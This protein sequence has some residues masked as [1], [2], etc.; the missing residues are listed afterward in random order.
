MRTLA[1][2]LLLMGTAAVLACAVPLTVLYTNDLH[3]RVDRLDGLSSAI[4]GVRMSGEAVLWLDAGDGWHDY[5]RPVAA[6]WGSD[7][8][9][10]WMNEAGLSA[11]V[12]GNH[13]TY[14]GPQR[15]SDRLSEAEFPVLAA[16]WRSND[17]RI[18]VQPSATVTVGDVQVLVI[19][20][21][22][23]DLFPAF[24]YPM[25]MCIDPAIAVQ[26]ELEEHAGTYDLVFVLAHMPTAQARV[27][28]RGIPEIDLFLTGHSH[29]RTDEPIVEGNALIVQAGAFGQ[30][31]GQLR[32]EVD[33][34]RLRVVSNDLDAIETAPADLRAGASKW[35]SV[36][37][38][39]LLAA[40]V[41]WT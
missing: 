22:T 28:A 40:A 10:A 35:L 19:G 5:R 11:M 38:A 6:V 20:L 25:M 9:V 41:W 31:L 27:L 32:L 21:M 39:I 7:V 16:N 23:P 18:E 30:A 14:L 13:E 26:E 12:L 1:M 29:E 8:M 4:A 3:V 2:T 34:G 24:A 37:A 36:L 17:P 33:D 15:L